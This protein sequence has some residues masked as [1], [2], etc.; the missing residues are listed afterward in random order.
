MIHGIQNS[1]IDNQHVLHSNQVILRNELMALQVSIG[2]IAAT[3]QNLQQ[4]ITAIQQSLIVPA[5]F[6]SFPAHSEQPLQDLNIPFEELQG[7]LNTH[8]ITDITDISNL[9][10][11][12]LQ[13]LST[14]DID[15]V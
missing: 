14:T 13:H 11:F 8:V 1:T 15:M 10:S 3:S 6:Q 9:D 7:S 4:Q 12:P 2:G 5:E